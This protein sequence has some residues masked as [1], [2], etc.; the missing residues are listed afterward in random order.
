MA[1]I[2]KNNVSGTLSTQL[3][4]ADTSM[5]LADA[6]NFP[7]P[8]GGDF[9]L[10]TLVGLNTNGQEDTWEVVKVTAK[11]ANTLTVVRAQESTAAATWPVGATVQ[12]RLTAG[13][14]ATQDALV[15]GLAT[16]EPTIAV[17]TTAQYRRGDKT[18]QTLDKAAAGLANV[19]NT[20]DATK[21]VLSATKLTTART[22]NGVSFDGSANISINAAAVPNT[23]AGSIAATTVQAAI[24]ELDSEKVSTVVV[25]PD[26]TDLDTVV[27][28]GFHRLRTV[29]NG[30]PVAVTDG[31]LI[32]SRGADTITQIAINYSSGRMFTRSG[33][34]PSVGGVGTFTPWREV[35]NAG[36]ILGTVSQSAG[37]PT[38][39]VIERGINANGEYVRFADG[40]QIC[41]ISFTGALSPT[42]YG[43]GGIY[44]SIF[45]WTLP[46]SHIG[47]VSVCANGVDSVTHG[48]GGG[49]RATDSSVDVFWFSLASSITNSG[50]RLLTIGRWY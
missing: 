4:P 45:T 41:G 24:N 5:V 22:I 33:S 20:A 25:L 1:Q 46:A 13:T 3:N 40:T 14:V 12:L 23:P 38:G 26:A 29:S 48:W 10:L 8:T 15:S 37:V 7:A 9:Y 18:W 47:D 49:L 50:I 16:K 39:A 2:L 28:S 11:A 36:S 21:A 44:R 17:G 31:Q 43:S 6:S 32:V 27:T 42:A 30:P 35:Y 34:P 19:D